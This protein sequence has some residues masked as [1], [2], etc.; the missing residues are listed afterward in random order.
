MASSSHHRDADA[1]TTDLAERIELLCRESDRG[2]LVEL[3]ASVGAEGL[4]ES[5]IRLIGAQPF[6]P[7]SVRAALDELEERAVE[8][9]L[10]NLT[11]PTRIFRSLPPGAVK[12]EQVWVCPTRR[13]T[14]AEGRLKPGARCSLTDR[15]LERVTLPI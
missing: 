9:G 6:E 11:I 12:G 7:D 2:D 1:G 3:L 8:A 10:Q 13:C 5:V 14:R 15:S 4:L